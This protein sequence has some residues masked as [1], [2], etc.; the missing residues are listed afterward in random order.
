MIGHLGLKRETACAE[1]PVVVRTIMAAAAHFKEAFTA[2][3][4]VAVVWSTGAVILL[5]NSMN[6]F[7]KLKKNSFSEKKLLR[8]MQ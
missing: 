3:M 8:F 6:K 7:Y 5:F 2:A 1:R 4:A